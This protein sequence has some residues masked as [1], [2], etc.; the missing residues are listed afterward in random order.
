MSVEL[1]PTNFIQRI[2]SMNETDRKKVRLQQLMSLILQVPDDISTESPNNSV[3]AEKLSELSAS[4]DYIKSMSTN[5]AAEIILLQTANQN[6]TVENN[7]SNDNNDLLKN[8]IKSL[9]QKLEAHQNHLYAIEKY[10]RVN[11]LEIVGFPEAENPGESK[12]EDTLIEIFNSLPDMKETPVTPND[13]DI[14]HV[15]PSD[16]KDKKLVAVCKF[17]SRKTKLMILNAKKNSRNFKYKN[18]DIFINDHLSPS[19]R[20]LFALASKKKRD[21][22]YKFL[23]TRDGA[24]FLRKDDSSPVINVVSEDIINSITAEFE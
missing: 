14:C 8:H 13:I 20:H 11:N 23:W 12:I 5:N 16:R 17:V 10:L 21:L 18:N 2:K 7:V 6:L 24:I 19:N 22:G 9:E 3:I 15:I 4:I 1:T